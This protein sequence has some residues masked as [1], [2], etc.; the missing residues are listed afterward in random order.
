MTREPMLVRDVAEAREHPL[1]QDQYFTTGSFISFPLVYHDELVGVVNLA[2][3]A[4][5]G[6]V[7][8]K[9]TSTACAC[10]GS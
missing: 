9:R 2:N 5:A 1:L 8:S 10:S 4:H 3:R 7:Q 6:H